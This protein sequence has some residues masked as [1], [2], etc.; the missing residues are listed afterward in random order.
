MG[1]TQIDKIKNL[2]RQDL[3]EENTV[4]KI[5]SAQ[6]ARGAQTFSPVTFSDASGKTVYL[7]AF[8]SDTNQC[9]NDSTS[10]FM[11]SVNGE[12]QNSP[13]KSAELIGL[14]QFNEDDEDHAGRNRFGGYSPVLSGSIKLSFNK[15]RQTA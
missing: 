7:Y 14:A 9:P 1:I 8:T 13:I 10:Q 4:Q 2:K 11:T 3:Y 12:G 5:V 6:N 15:K